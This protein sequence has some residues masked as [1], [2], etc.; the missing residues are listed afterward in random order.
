MKLKA[1]SCNKTLLRKDIFRFAPL[2]GI[3]LIGGLLVML[4]SLTNVADQDAYWLSATLGPFAIINMIYAVLVAQMLFGDL[5][6]SRLCNALHALPMRRETWFCTHVVA[7]LAYSLVPHLI[8]AVFFMTT[9][10]QYGWVALTWV[11]VM[12]MEYLFFFGVAVFCVFCTGNRFAQVAVYAIVNFFAM[13]VYWF[14][15]VIYQPMLYGV[16]INEDVF[17][18]FCPVAQMVS[19]QLLKFEWVVPTSVLSHIHA[20]G[21][22]TYMG[23]G[24]GWGYLGI[25]A[26]IGVAL[27]AAALLLYRRRRLECAGE[28]VAIQRL[29]PVLGVVFALCV[30][31]VVAAFGQEMMGS[32]GYLVF[33]IIGLAVGWFAGQMLLQRTVRVFTGKTF[34]HLVALGLILAMT[35]GLTAWDPIGITRYVPPAEAV[36]SVEI[37]RGL[38]YSYNEPD[39][40]ITDDEGIEL[41][42]TIHQQAL[43]ERW[44]G[45][46][47]YSTYSIRYTLE[48]GQQVIRSYKILSGS[49]AA[50]LIQT[51]Y[52]RPVFLLGETDWAT[53]YQS[54]RNIQFC[55]YTVEQLV[56]NYNELMKEELKVP[57]S[58]Y[59]VKNELLRAIWNDAH[60]GNLNEIYD[61]DYEELSV[62]YVNFDRNL[63]NGRAQWKEFYIYKRA[64][65][66]QKWIEKYQQVLI[67]NG[68][69]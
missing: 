52:S 21:Q 9:L 27:L 68:I 7:G 28:F 59:T 67:V 4:S 19:S 46:G 17:K 47:N 10:G 14:A 11:A 12:L 69:I 20:E 8:G 43:Q 25:C 51:L 26:G 53:W 13:I 34:A 33:L 65:N 38:F 63:E 29:K 22:W 37:D 18:L 49:K 58:S 57:L 24:E 16:Q 41:V 64:E 3:Y 5:Y 2:W 30:G 40:K 42:R 62:Y 1:L 31:A 35:V 61:K 48:S 66:C 55:G 50:E 60:A 36:Q 32:D 39:M 44:N 56:I 6:K 15:T 54:I 23:P 45:S